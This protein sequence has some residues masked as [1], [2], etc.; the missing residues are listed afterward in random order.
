M[1]RQELEDLRQHILHNFSMNPAGFV[2]D[3]ISYLVVTEELKRFGSCKD[4]Y[5]K[6]PCATKGPNS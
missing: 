3:Y 6:D 2:L 1:T 4:D 5:P